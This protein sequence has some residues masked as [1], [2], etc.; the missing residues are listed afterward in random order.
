[1][2][3]DGDNATAARQAWGETVPGE[4]ADARRDRPLVSIGLPVFNGAHHL[5]QTLEALGKQTLTDYQLLISDN[6]STDGTEAICRAAAATDPRVS[7]QRNEENLGAARNFELL[8]ERARGRTSSGPRPTT[9]GTPRSSRSAWR[10]WTAVRRS[11][12][13]IAMHAV[14]TPMERPSCC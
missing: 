6:A 2:Q 7:Y 9:A 5:P 11:S 4:V 14:S 12:S 8:V 3:R 1:M 10:S 13:V